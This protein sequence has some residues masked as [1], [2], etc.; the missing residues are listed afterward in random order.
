MKIVIFGGSGFIGRHLCHALAEDA[1]SVTV[2]SRNSE[3]AS[4]H[5]DPRV[6]VQEWDP[7]EWGT[8]EKVIDGKDVIINLAGEP[9]ADSRWTE[10]RKKALRDSRVHITHLL[11]N[12]LSRL[13]PAPKVLINA[14]G[15]GFYGLTSSTPVNEDTPVG[16]GFLADLC[17]DWEKEAAR[18]RLLGTRVVC[19]RI[20]MVLGH[21]GGAL[22]KMILPF[23]L[24]A[25]GPILPGTQPVSWIHY[26]D[27]VN[28]IRFILD[29]DSIS[30]PVNA[31]SPEPVTMKVFCQTLGQ[32]LRRPSW[33]PVPEFLLKIGLGEMATLMTTG[34]AV[35]PGV[36][37][38][39]GFAFS[40]PTLGPA[41][42][43]VVKE[44]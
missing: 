4:T 7:L 37:K 10:S 42:K 43:S 18:A 3:K 38:K 21:D 39:F 32:A 9:I 25:G 12:A 23:R 19:L 26:H 41:L 15:I 24:F 17:V 34:Q 8:L 2:L 20:G 29:H 27:L 35:E 11:I 14:S 31:V 30:G 44:S 13:K 28:L 22:P 33:F 36:A 40:Y 5:L 16:K 1:H 6:T